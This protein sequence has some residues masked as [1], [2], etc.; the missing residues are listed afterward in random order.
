[1]SYIQA[2]IVL[3]KLV[4][5]TNQ[6][7]SS[8]NLIT[9]ESP[10]YLFINSA[11]KTV[12]LKMKSFTDDF[13]KEQINQQ[14]QCHSIVF[15]N[16]VTTIIQGKELSY[17][18]YKCYHKHMDKGFVYYQTVN[19]ESLQPVGDLQFSNQEENIFFNLPEPDFEESSCNAL[20]AK[21]STAENKK[22]VF[23]IGNMNEE[24]LLFDIERLIVTTLYNTCKH[25]TLKFH[26]IINIAKFGGDIDNSF[27]QKLMPVKKETQT[28]LAGFPNITFAFEYA[29]QDS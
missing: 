20:E 21:G 1:M 19:K 28:L 24:R 4:T 8:D 27:D 6:S 15:T 5:V 25:P 7:I 9:Q 14:P 13:I 2:A 23:L 29:E 22:I 10:N 26:F 18:L 3:N 16:L 11:Q 17:I 12:Q